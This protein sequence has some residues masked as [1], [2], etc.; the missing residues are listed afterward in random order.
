MIRQ[1][2]LE[3]QVA[4]MKKE[5]ALFEETVDHLQAGI[6]KTNF[7]ELI[8]QIHE[9]NEEQENLLILL[10]D[11]QSKLKKYK[12]LA[13]KRGD[14]VSED[15]E[16][17]D[18]EEEDDNEKKSQEQNMIVNLN[19]LPALN[20]V[21]PVKHHTPQISPYP[22]EIHASYQPANSHMPHESTPLSDNN[23]IMPP[24]DQFHQYHQ[25]YS[26]HQSYPV[27]E[28]SSPSHQPRDPTPNEE[29]DDN[30]DLKPKNNIYKIIES[31]VH[32]NSHSGDDTSS[33]VSNTPHHFHNHSSDDSQQS[34][35]Q[36]SNLNINEPPRPQILDSFAHNPQQQQYFNPNANFMQYFHNPEQTQMYQKQAYSD[37]SDVQTQPANHHSAANPLQNYF[38]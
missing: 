25:Y 23:N 27:I 36:Q 5:R 28:I 22:I 8:Q 7:N 13:K 2:E 11:L 18:E 33:L 12:K 30:Q 38:K 29:S 24:T 10:T 32:S 20:L 9:L 3:A 35:S 37:V 34:T 21:Q 14:P 16:E 17:E 4:R 31:N 1:T 19:E 26:D 6:G 15:E